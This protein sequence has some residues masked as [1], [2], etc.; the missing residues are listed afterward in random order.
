MS[1]N[2][3]FEPC[4]PYEPNDETVADELVIVEKVYWKEK[5]IF[6]IV[7]DP[8]QTNDFLVYGNSEF[9]P[10]KAFIVRKDLWSIEICRTKIAV[11]VDEFESWL[12]AMWFRPRSATA[13]TLAPKTKRTETA[14]IPHL[15]LKP[16]TGS[17][18]EVAS[19]KN[20]PTVQLVIAELAY[21]LGIIKERAVND[22]YVI[23]KLDLTERET[24]AHILRA[25]E[26]DLAAMSRSDLVAFM[27]DDS[28]VNSKPQLHDLL[29]YLEVIL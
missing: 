18:A 9:W 26:E 25:W 22:A 28:C 17:A 7:Q 19:N 3:K 13:E 5:L 6:K 2:L 10:L 16:Y 14:G 4:W 24:D 29:L 21:D 8:A 11:M 20:Y 23:G 27:F 12:S 15:P 1:A